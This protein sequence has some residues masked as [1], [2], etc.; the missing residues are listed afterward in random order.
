MLLE[1]FPAKWIPVRV[2]KKRQ[3]KRLEPGSDSIRTDKALVGHA[4]VRLKAPAQL[5]G[6]HEAGAKPLALAPDQ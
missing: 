1:R 5:L 4:P 2:K 6:G 3:N